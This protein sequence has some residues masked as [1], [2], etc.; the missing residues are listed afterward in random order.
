MIGIHADPATLYGTLVVGLD[1]LVKAT[2]LIVLAAAV[3]LT[4]GG[5][6]RLLWRSAVWNALLVALTILPL[7]AVSF[8]RLRIHCLPA[9]PNPVVA[10]TGSTRVPSLESV[11]AAKPVGDLATTTRLPARAAVPDRLKP[12][13]P[14]TESPTVDPKKASLPETLSPEVRATPSS[15]RRGHLWLGCGLGVYLA[16]AG[17]LLMRLVASLAD[18]RRLRRTAIVLD[19]AGWAASLKRWRERLGIDRRVI[20]AVSPSVNVPLA[21]GWL[22]P[23][24]LIPETLVDVLDPAQRDVV[25]LHELAHVRREDYPWQILLK[26][27]QAVYWLHPLVWAV[28]RSVTTVREAA[29]DD[30]CAYHAATPQQYRATLVRVAANLVRRPAVSLGI[31]MARSTKLAGRLARIDGMRG[32][33][34]CLAGRSTR[35]LAATLA[36]I[37]VFTIGPLELARRTARAEKAPD[38]AA[39]RPTPA[40][41]SAPA[42]KP[43]LDFRVVDK[44][45]G[46]PLGDVALRVRVNDAVRTVTTD[47]DGRYRVELD[48]RHPS[49]LSIRVYKPTFVPMVVG[50]DEESDPAGVPESYTFKL[51]TGSP[52]G[53]VVRNENGQPVEGVTGLVMTGQNDGRDRYNLW[54]YPVKTDAEGRWVCEAF[55]RKTG[56]I[57]VKFEH[58][59]YA[60]T[61]ITYQDSGDTVELLRK[62]T[63]V[64]V[65]RKPPVLTGR[66]LDEKGSPLAGAIVGMRT[67]T[68]SD[69]ESKRVT[70]NDKGEFRLVYTGALQSFTSLLLTATFKDRAPDRKWVPLNEPIKPLEFQ[71]GLGRTIRGRIT[72]MADKPL[73]DVAVAVK[74]WRGFHPLDW[75]A[76]TDNDGRFTWKNAP[77]DGVVLSARKSG[78]VDG[79]FNTG[80][81]DAGKA[82]EV[83]IRMAA[84]DPAK[85]PPETTNLRVHGS[86]VDAETG[87]PIPRFEVIPGMLFETWTNVHW[88]RE[89][90]KTCADGTYECTFDQAFRGRFLKIEVDGYAPGVSK[91][92][93]GNEGD[94]VLDFRLKRQAGPQGVVRFPD[95]KPVAGALVGLATSAYGGGLRFQN[96]RLTVYNPAIITQTDA[97]GR[98]SF[99]AQSE[100]WF[101][102]AMHDD[103]Y[104]EMTAQTL[105][106][107]SSVVLQPWARVEGSL[108]VGGKPVANEFVVINYVNREAYSGFDLDLSR[109]DYW[110]EVATD[111]N[112]FFRMDKLPPGDA[113]IAHGPKHGQVEDRNG[114]RVTIQPGQTVQLALGELRG[115]SVIGKAVLAPELPGPVDWTKAVAALSSAAPPEY[116]TFNG[117]Q[118]AY[119]K[120]RAAFYATEAGRRYWRYERHSPVTLAPD[121][122]FRIEQVVAGKYTIDVALRDP[123]DVKKKT[124]VGTLLFDV[125]EMPDGRS[126]EPLDVGEL[127]M[128]PPWP[129]VETPSLSGAQTAPADK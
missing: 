30:L 77:T 95:G 41:G 93:V 57:Q 97:E 45:T 92:Y 16:G 69:K 99:P 37:T 68:V 31:A 42:E 4:M 59:D 5:P 54:D 110:Y 58:P 75:R 43:S 13:L 20:L 39:T 73:A 14:S 128:E 38:P 103:G 114:V 127:K 96:G 44:D 125:P 89:R 86:V 21:F 108:K 82:S 50:W 98:F 76:Q 88:E 15:P 32:T 33:G 65:M 62:R 48:N 126:S 102:V 78:Y 111:E 74:E 23:T 12:M 122:S 72:D 119:G 87:R 80:S 117:D 70:T 19:D 106:A 28:S 36:L 26:L 66:V 46:K 52:I 35:M 64:T 47:K 29:C 24:V 81:G 18:V 115:R 112:G 53:G 71:L 61:A 17:V 6:R 9:L 90:K 7:A 25:L 107:N 51:E 104:R 94:V 1:V 105:N 79:V 63:H 11:A 116:P 49:I 123:Q 8:P 85:V 118:N 109:I 83:T 34:H 22:Q 101:L 56:N 27:V 120:A 3:T 40:S 121:G 91:K 129:K 113:T 60:A 124:G 100:D 10:V 84:V 67:N 2:A 55:P